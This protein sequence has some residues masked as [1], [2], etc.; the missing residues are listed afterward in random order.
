MSRKPYYSFAFW[1]LCH[2][3]D[4][5]RHKSQ[6]YKLTFGTGH[7]NTFLFFWMNRI[8]NV[9]DLDWKG[10]EKTTAQEWVREL[11]IALQPRAL[12]LPCTLPVGAGCRSEDALGVGEAGAPDTNLCDGSRKMDTA[13][14]PPRLGSR[15]GERTRSS[16][17]CLNSGCKVECKH[18]WAMSIQR[19]SPRCPCTHGPLTA[20]HF[21]SGGGPC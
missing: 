16:G 14:H 4:E 11:W 7:R 19:P 10:G 13:G 21:L 8:I 3:H 18:T 15:E 5:A 1:W 17:N 6:Q 20:Y 2:F 12:G 9:A